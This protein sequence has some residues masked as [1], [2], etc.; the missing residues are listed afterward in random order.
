MDEKTKEAIANVLKG[1]II[2]L[3]AILFQFWFLELELYEP[4]SAFLRQYSRTITILLSG[5]IVAGIF[6][7]IF[8]GILNEDEEESTS[9][10]I[11]SIIIILVI[12]VLSVSR[13]AF[14]W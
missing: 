6:V 9:P 5:L 14:I 3:V 4:I 13:I 11:P 1:I 10:N 12:L 8:G 7:K 2:V